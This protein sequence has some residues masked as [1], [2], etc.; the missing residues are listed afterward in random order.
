[1]ALVTIIVLMAIGWGY[2]YYHYKSKLNEISQTLVQDQL[3][4]LS[5]RLV[6]CKESLTLAKTN[7]LG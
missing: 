4:I 1:M 3:A 7:Y 5:P 6:P 2:T